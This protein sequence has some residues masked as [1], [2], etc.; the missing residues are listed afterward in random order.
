MEGAMTTWRQRVGVV[1]GVALLA[2][3]ALGVAQVAR[4]V[5]GQLRAAQY[6][7]D[8]Q[9]DVAGAIADY[10]R[11]AAGPDRTAAA[12]ATLEMAATFERFG[13]GD[14]RAV[15]TGLVR[16]YADQPEVVRAANTRLAA[17]TQAGDLTP[18]R[19]HADPDFPVSFSS[20]GRY[21][22]VVTNETTPRLLLRELTTGQERVLVTGV[23]RSLGR[24]PVMSPDGRLVAFSWLARGPVGTNAGAEALHLVGTEPGAAPRA[25]TP[26]VRVGQLIP[27]A[28]S[29]DSRS[30]LVKR[31]GPGGGWGAAGGALAWVSAADGAV[32]TIKAF[33]DWR[34]VGVGGFQGP[35]SVRLSHGGTTIAYSAEVADGSPDRYIFTVDANGGNETAVVKV[36]GR[37]THP[38]WT[39][40]D[41]H[42]LFLNDR[43]G[44]IGLWGV[45]MNGAAPDG[46]PFPVQSTFPGPIVD[47]TPG[48]D[49]F[50]L[51]VNEASKSSLPFTQYIATRDPGDSTILQSFPGMSGAWSRTNRLAYYSGIGTLIVRDMGTGEER[52]YRQDGLTNVSPTWLEAANA[53][54]VFVDPG[55]AGHG[56]DF[57]RLDLATGTFTRIFARDTATH[58]RSRVTAA[59][60]DGR[61]LYAVVRGSAKGRWTGVVGIDVATGNETPV[62]T[63][64]GTGL[65][66]RS[67][68]S[69]AVS[70]DGAT[71]AIKAWVDDTSGQGRIITVGTDGTG[72][73]DLHGPFGG[74]GWEYVLRWTPDGQSIVF[75]AGG[76]QAGGWRLMRIPAT[77]GT[78]EF[79]GLERARF[80][81]AVPAPVNISSFD[82]SPDGS[83]VAF[84]SRNQTIYE[85]WTLDNVLNVLNAR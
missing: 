46:E 84:S 38:T 32:R 70:P 83:R 25:L 1:F 72:Y 37:N 78:A 9:G 41:S 40:S 59:S 4:S 45:R 76:P 13:A 58:Q 19:W 5:D 57:Y 85:L 80:S 55:I 62:I 18:R 2:G 56:G 42:L 79:E 51:T 26:A 60:P 64:T 47:M 22:L 10:R 36:A 33:E 31:A 28:W 30:I 27:I 39:P 21:G 23:G 17:M 66:G 63:F 75:T 3:Q 67:E 82:I 54:V 12:R 65:P 7:A 68:P 29:S 16:D 49:L 48:G 6:K 81:S 44:Q 43:D 15:L 61:T 50:Y 14:A 11:I 73:R 71:I 77:G 53:F 35:T 34:N 20:D 8:V 52:T 74:G 24:W 69:L